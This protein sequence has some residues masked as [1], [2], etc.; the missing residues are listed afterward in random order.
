MTG[1]TRPTSLGR[2]SRFAPGQNSAG[3]SSQAS[4]NQ[5]YGAPCPHHGQSGRH[6]APTDAATSE[7]QVAADSRPAQPLALGGNPP[8]RQLKP[9]R[10]PYTPRGH[11]PRSR[12]R[13]IRSAAHEP[14][15]GLPSPAHT[16]V[17]G[18]P[19]SGILNQRPEEPPSRCTCPRVS[20]RVRLP[21]GPRRTQQPW[22]EQGQDKPPPWASQTARDGRQ[23]PPPWGPRCSLYGSISRYANCLLP[24]APGC[25]RPARCRQSRALVGPQRSMRKPGARSSG[26]CPSGLRWQAALREGPTPTGSHSVSAWSRPMAPWA[27]PSLRGSRCPHSTRPGID[28]RGPSRRSCP[29]APFWTHLTSASDT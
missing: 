17:Q 7:H 14:H 6:D 18:R 4:W 26:R 9:K 21:G 22:Q 23:R 24:A 19:S 16:H 1:E 11:L 29:R 10:P 27:G 28:A 20:C 13:P 2:T 15:H 8:R 3:N 25:G 12:Y 5:A